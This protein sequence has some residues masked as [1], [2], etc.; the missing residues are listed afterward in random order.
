MNTPQKTKQ[1]T[2]LLS[3]S[4]LLVSW[5]VGY[6]FL[7]Y[8]FTNSINKELEKISQS[9][10]KLFK[11]KL[12]AQSMALSLKLD[13]IVSSDGLAK[14]VAQRD[15]QKLDAIITPYY[16][17]LKR[18]NKEINILTFRSA[19]GTTIYR[20]HKREF[21]GDKLNK[22][23]TLIVDTNNMQRSFNG[24]EVDNLDM[25][26]RI[27]QAVFYKNRYVGSV[28]LGISP[29]YFVQDLNLIFDIEI[30]LAIKKPISELIVEN[31]KVSIDKD[32]TLVRGSQN[33]KNYF[34]DRESTPN[35]KV[36][37][38]IP[39]QNHLNQTLGYLVVGLDISGIVSQNRDFMYKLLFIGVFVA[40]LLVIVLHKSF[41]MMLEHF[42]KQVF[43]D[44]LT[45]LK[46]RQAL[47]TKLY[48]GEAYVLILSNIKEF[49][50][51][52]EIYGIDVGN[53]VL[54]QV[55][56]E[57]ERFA[58]ANGFSSYRISA[59]EYVLLR[60][61]KNIQVDVYSDIL[62]RLHQKI[63][64]LSIYVPL[65]EETLRVE[66]YSGVSFDHE[67]SLEQAQMAI[68]K[69]KEK[70]LPYLAYS[71]NVDSKKSSQHILGMKKIIRHALDNKNV[72]PFFQPITDRDGVIVKYEALVR[73]I[74]YEHGRKNIIFPDDFLPVAIKSGLYIDV[75]R[76]VL[77][78]ALDVFARRS[79]KISINL[80]P[81]D[82]FNYSLM[83][84]LV[85]LIAT[86]D[87]PQKIVLEITEQEGVEDFDRLH[88]AIKEFRRQGV[89]IAIDDFGS[90][91]ANYAHIL[92]IRPD[93][94]KIDGSLIKNI[95]E[96]HESQILVRSIIRFAKD[97]KTKTIAE[98][99]E[100]KE[101][102][103]LLKEYGV[104]EFQGYYF[105][106]PKDLINSYK[107]IEII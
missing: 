7:N 34:R 64:A 27:T 58:K 102:Y 83:D 51:L 75:A 92:K 94:L 11:A 44:H 56:N 89:L 12:T 84:K 18:V 57:H 37:M 9:I 78:Q 73:I 61:E 63:N 13:E 35:F 54:I 41:N 86:F 39:L 28:E 47:N 62:D 105:G 29:K 10:Q 4:V 65:I 31:D 67:L 20:A 33:L 25:S 93:Y 99:V 36:N 91:Y 101:I 77:S 72:I 85:E 103:E 40:I 42:K 88:R 107:E 69:A 22:K 17:R 21:R 100:N 45:G 106:R 15:Y 50:L 60:E 96:D 1:K 5:I 81:N 71:Q 30:G 46:N 66:I 74:N 32:Y 49:R 76:E 23:R 48:S 68:K 87:T 79:E 59:D 16:K 82:F 8:Q 3:T 43:T 38:D 55:A 24:F 14:A 2:L 95:L 70:A 6:L 80:L 53:E 98:F 90:G 97:L 52:N 104:D 19:N 26:Y